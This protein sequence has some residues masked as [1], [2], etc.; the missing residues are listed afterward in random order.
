ILDEDQ[1]GATGRSCDVDAACAGVECVLHQLLHRARR[2]LHHLA[3]GDAVHGAFGQAA[4]L[5]GASIAEGRRRTP[6]RLWMVARPGRKTPA[7][8]RFL[9]WG[10]PK[11]RCTRTLLAKERAR[12]S[13]RRVWAG[14]VRTVSKVRLLRRQYADPG[15]VRG[16]E[17]A[18]AAALHGRRRMMPPCPL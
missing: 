9:G 15:D 12:A 13:L 7:A 4:N 6:T 8:L 14:R 18:F 5:H 10:P 1:I 3:G 11:K 16:Y 17:G 2:A